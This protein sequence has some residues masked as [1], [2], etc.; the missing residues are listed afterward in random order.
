MGQRGTVALVL[1]YCCSLA[2]TDKPVSSDEPK[3]LDTTATSRVIE[4][5]ATASQGHAGSKDKTDSMLAFTLLYQIQVYTFSYN[6][7]Y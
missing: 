4:G 1:L 7:Q 5:R 6:L 2:S 3:P